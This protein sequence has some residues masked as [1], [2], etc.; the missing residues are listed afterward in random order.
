M[1]CLKK[2]SNFFFNFVIVLS[3]FFILFSEVNCLIKNIGWEMNEEIIY[4]CFK[5][6]V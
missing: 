2:K 1:V 3:M 6:I 4:K 5:W